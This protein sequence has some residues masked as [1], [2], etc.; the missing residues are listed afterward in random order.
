MSVKIGHTTR[1]VLGDV[2][3]SGF[4]C[5]NGN[6]VPITWKKPNFV[7]MGKQDGSKGGVL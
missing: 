1:F 7:L 4:V 5:S 6:P 3:P 2:P